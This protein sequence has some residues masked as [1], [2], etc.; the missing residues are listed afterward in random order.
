MPQGRQWGGVGGKRAE[1]PSP[2][3]QLLLGLGFFVGVGSR[4]GSEWAGLFARPLTTRSAP[5]NKGG[6]GQGGKVSG[7]VSWRV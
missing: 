5:Q 1:A 3:G 4:D 7:F 6:T 2:V